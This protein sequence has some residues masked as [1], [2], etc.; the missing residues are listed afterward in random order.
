MKG[1]IK[2]VF[3]ALM[4]AAVGISAAGC[5]EASTME[6]IEKSGKLVVGTSADYAPYEYH[7]MIEGKD[8][9]IGIDISIVN[10][11]AK[12][13]GVQLEIVDTGF[14]GLLAALN[15]DKVDIV[16]AG[17]NPDEKR[18]KAVD[19]SK[20]YY[21]AKQGVMVRAEDKDKI[22]TIADLSGKNVGVQLG[23]TQE[24]IAQDQMTASK[25]VSLGKI[26]DLVMELKNNKID[27]LVV[28]LP[29]ANGY[30]KNNNDLALSEINVE[31]DSGGSAIA[32][33]K[34]NEDFVA[35]L[36]KSLDR[37]IEEGSIDKF[38]QEA[39]EK[40]VTQ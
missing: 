24:K 7:T 18:K 37:L 35:L 34:G 17:M 10:E 30:I 19:F 4:V 38:V 16:I 31:E 23:T 6:R 13:L 21:E 15:S 1:I 20:I 14:D 33:K 28:E 22:K 2:K 32:V 12:D 27:A 3:C 11:I 29:V 40:N 26:P 5:G 39:N 25:L 9:I 36:N 8:T